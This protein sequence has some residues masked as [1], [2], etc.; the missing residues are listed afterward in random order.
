MRFFPA[1]AEMLEQMRNIQAC[2]YKQRAAHAL[3]CDRLA[4]EHDAEH[5]RKRRALVRQQPV[6]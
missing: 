6:L 5:R 1:H 3:N 4:E 2:E